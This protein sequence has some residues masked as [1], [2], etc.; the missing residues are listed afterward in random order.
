MLKSKHAWLAIAVFALVWD[1]LCDV[2]ETLSAGFWRASKSWT[3]PLWLAL[4]AHLLFRTPLPVR[5]LRVRP[6]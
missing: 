6:W 4:S 2:D 1:N 5:F 3:F